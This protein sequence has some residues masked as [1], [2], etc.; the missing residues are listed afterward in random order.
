[1]GNQA[2]PAVNAA[3]LMV[4]RMCLLQRLGWARWVVFIL[5]Q[6]MNSI[7]GLHSRMSNV[8]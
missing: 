6:P 2:F 4:S 3:N 5:E 7:M 1:M 8:E